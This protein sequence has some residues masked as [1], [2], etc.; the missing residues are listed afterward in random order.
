MI[1]GSSPEACIVMLLCPQPMS[2][3]EV[4]VIENARVIAKFMGKS[5]YLK[6]HSIYQGSYVCVYICHVLCIVCMYV[7]VFFLNAKNV[8]FKNK[9]HKLTWYPFVHS[10]KTNKKKGFPIRNI[11]ASDA[12]ELDDINEK[13]IIYRYQNKKSE[14]NL[15]HF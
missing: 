2:D 12:S 5:Q 7:C 15:F 3:I 10:K 11:I 13:Y 14:T 6:F 9:S 8:K 1:F 4:I